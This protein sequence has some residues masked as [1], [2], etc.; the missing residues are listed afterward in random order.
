MS[1]DNR[2][3]TLRL[4]EEIRK[5]VE[6][7]AMADNEPRFCSA[8]IIFGGL[9][10]LL[11]LGAIA[12]LMA[13]SFKLSIVSVMTSLYLIMVSQLEGKPLSAWKQAGKR[14]QK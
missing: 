11:L 12:D 4:L 7:S 13:G 2:S 9:L 10:G 8:Q 1:N 14:K 5:N 3:E 6:V